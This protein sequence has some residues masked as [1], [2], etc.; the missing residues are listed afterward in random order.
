MSRSPSAI[1]S[2]IPVGVSACLMGERVRYDGAHKRDSYLT[3]TLARH[4]ELIP[5][6]P[7]VAV[8]LGVPRPPIQLRQAP[9]GVRAVGVQRPHRDVS[10]PLCAY[11][12]EV[13]AGHDG[14]CGYIF[15]HGSPSCGL[16]Q[17]PIHDRGGIPVQRG[18]GLF[19][20][21]LTE[22]MPLLPVVDEGGLQDPARR[23]SFLT[24]V[25]V[26]HRWQATVAAAPSA[27]ALVQFHT[28]HKLLLLAHDE[29][30]YRELGPLVSGAG[31]GDLAARSERY[32]AALLAALARP[33]SRGGHT[34]ALMHA[35]GFLKE[36]ASA[37]D[38]ARLREAIEAYRTG[39]LPLQVP[40][41]LLR[42]AGHP[43]LER[44][45]YLRPY[46]DELLLA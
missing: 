1:P 18:R 13:A 8:G 19:A 7:E 44:Q 12:Q 15:K 20:A 17:V 35:L 43:Y 5:F 45:V 3:E 10:E 29:P 4:L 40:I 34:N 33:A 28:E 6:C 26:L 41:G 46:P 9:G 16:H 25:Y 2:P 42:R 32:V 23:A 37:G 14:L 22:A 31:E 36:M 30:L 27:A 11:G 24:R 21:A 39:R 38:R